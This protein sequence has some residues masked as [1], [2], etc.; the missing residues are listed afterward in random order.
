MGPRGEYMEHG[1]WAVGGLVRRERDLAPSCGARNEGASIC[2]SFIPSTLSGVVHE[3]LSFFKGVCIFGEKRMLLVAWKKFH[4]VG[5]RGWH[6]LINWPN[7][8]KWPWKG[9]GIHVTLSFSTSFMS[10][11]YVPPS[12]F[13]TTLPRLSLL[14]ATCPPFLSFQHLTLCSHFQSP[15][16]L[17]MSA[18]SWR[19]KYYLS[20]HHLS[21]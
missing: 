19:P 14:P 10:P 17:F 21:P 11:L 12:L 2:I 3:P 8:V 18:L 16:Y 6:V 7:R 9:R 13:V 15:L 5:T 20:Y 1:Q 4:V